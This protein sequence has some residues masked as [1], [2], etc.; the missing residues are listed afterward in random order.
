MIYNHHHRTPLS[1]QELK[2][3]GDKQI[4]EAHRVVTDS[5]RI[6]HEVTELHAETKRLHDRFHGSASEQNP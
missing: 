5:R 6:A 3:L 2:Q 1:L 4:A